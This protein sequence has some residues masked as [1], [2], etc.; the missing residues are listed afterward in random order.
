[1]DDDGNTA[2]QKTV[3]EQRAERSAPP[4]SV[5]ARATNDAPSQA[6]VREWIGTDQ[7]RKDQA[8]AAY[9]KIKLEKKLTGTKLWDEVKKEVGA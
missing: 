1:V 6:E 8:N 3:G 4:A 2:S 5:Q 7:A 9:E